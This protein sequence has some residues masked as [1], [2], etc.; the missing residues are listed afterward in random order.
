MVGIAVIGCGYWGSKHVRVFSELPDA[1]LAMVADASEARR[2]HV[3]RSYP[4]TPTT[5]D[6]QDILSNPDVQGVVI[7]TPVST[8]Y[9]LAREALLAGKDVLVEKPLTDD[10]RK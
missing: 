7:A 8:H 10:C 2:A 3:E 6:H 5:A 1:R 4:N 9:Q